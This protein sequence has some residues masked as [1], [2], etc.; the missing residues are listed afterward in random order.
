MATVT[1]NNSPVHSESSISRVYGYISSSYSCGFHTGVDIVPHGTTGNNPPIYPT[2]NGEIVYINRSDPTNALG[3]Y[4][5]IKDSQTRY[6]RYCHLSLVNPTLN[7]NDSINTNT[8]LGLM[9]DTGNTTGI[10]LHLECSSTQNWDC[11]TF[12]NP[13][14]ILGIPNEVGTIIEYGTPQPTIKKK[15]F[16][17]VLYARKLRAR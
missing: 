14:D 2:Y 11:S 13:C 3:Y 15:K 10:H 4:V 6:W 12:Y 8:G 16:P 9:G 5:V 7:V 17:W 1:I